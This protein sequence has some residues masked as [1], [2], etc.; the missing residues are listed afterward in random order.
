M[1]PTRIRKSRMPFFVLTALVLMG[2][3]NVSFGATRF[4][5]PLQG[6]T[7]RTGRVFVVK[8]APGVEEIN[9]HIRY[10]IW[11]SNNGAAFTMIHNH[12]TQCDPDHPGADTTWKWLSPGP[13]GTNMRLKVKVY[14]DDFL[15]MQANSGAFTIQAAAASTEDQEKAGIGDDVVKPEKPIGEVS[16]IE[17]LPVDPGRD[18][19]AVEDHQSL[20]VIVPGLHVVIPNGGEVYSK[21]QKA[22]IE[23]KCDQAVI[24]Y[25][26][27][28]STDGGETWSSLAKNLS[29][30]QTSYDWNVKQGNAQDCLIKV[31]GAQAKGK[32]LED[33]SD[34][35]F[36]IIQKQRGPLNEPTPK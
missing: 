1:N 17:P 34:D 29:R 6:A 14:E 31:V 16:P 8:W 3:L 13:V 33:Q 30:S 28:L 35:A 21:G 36:L 24:N 15:V 27:M 7:L 18:V 2:A 9:R 23:W 4:W 22:R 10:E 5:A 25:S 19:K 12:I 11:L 20:D 32:T 26:I